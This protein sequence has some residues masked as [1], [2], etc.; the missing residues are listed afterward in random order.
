MKK[1]L[2]G[3]GVFKNT[4]L[5]C[6]QNKRSSIFS[7]PKGW[8]GF[9]G[10]HNKLWAKEKDIFILYNNIVVYLLI[11]I[12][13]TRYYCI[14]Y[15]SLKS[16]TNNCRSEYPSA[17]H[18]CTL[19]REKKLSDTIWWAKDGNM[20]WTRKEFSITYIVTSLF[21]DICDDYLILLSRLGLKFNAN[22]Q[23]MHGL[24]DNK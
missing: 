17:I 8:P 2:W 20:L 22:N 24:N 21:R 10:L 16:F 3:G 9:K 14:I 18:A 7:L 13:P 23:N 1:Y 15:K 5:K 12:H 4:F 6:K 19:F 11:S